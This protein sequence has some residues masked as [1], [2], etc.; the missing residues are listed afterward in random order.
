[1]NTDETR[2]RWGEATDELSTISLMP[3]KWF[4]GTSRALPE[5]NFFLLC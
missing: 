2:I 4:T 5:K 3:T 1:M